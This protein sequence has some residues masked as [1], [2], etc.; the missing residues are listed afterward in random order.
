MEYTRSWIRDLSVSVFA[1]FFVTLI[2]ALLAYS[3]ISIESLV[4]RRIALIIVFVLFAANAFVWLWG[5]FWIAVR[6]QSFRCRVTSNFVE[7]VCPIPTRGSSFKLP[8]NE[9]ASVS[10][11]AREGEGE[12][13]TLTSHDGVKYDLTYWY[14]NPVWRVV[15][16]IAEQDPE[17]TVLDFGARRLPLDPTVNASQNAS[18]S[19]CNRYLFR[20]WVSRR[21]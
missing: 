16:A 15:D 12:R 17:I 10:L 19:R 2:C 8:L 21:G 20:S 14:G 9:L 18:S 11:S 3:A 4:T 13:C 6:R 7:C 5:I 1:L